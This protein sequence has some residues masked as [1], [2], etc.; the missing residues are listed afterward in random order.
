MA[1]TETE[2]PLSIAGTGGYAVLGPDEAQR[3]RYQR[4]ANREIDLV[5]LEHF[6]IPAREVKLFEQRAALLQTIERHVGQSIGG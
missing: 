6:E 2:T 4:I 1:P 5:E 3:A